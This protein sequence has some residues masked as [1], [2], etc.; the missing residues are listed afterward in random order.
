MDIR[1]FVHAVCIFW[2]CDACVVCVCVVSVVGLPVIGS[3][4][5]VLMAE[6]CAVAT[7]VSQASKVV[8]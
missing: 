3:R 7:A 6:S 1:K 4:S 8:P 5:E 2:W